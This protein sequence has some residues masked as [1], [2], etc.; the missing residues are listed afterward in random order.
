K[1]PQ[2]L[3]PLA[4][5]RPNEGDTGQIAPGSRQARDNAGSVRERGLTKDDWNR[6]GR[7]LCSKGRGSAE[8]ADDV[9]LEFSER[10]CEPR[11]PGRVTVS[12]AGFNSNVPPLDVTQRR[13]TLSQRLKFVRACRRRGWGEPADSVNLP[14]RRA[15]ERRKRETQNENDREPDPPHRHLGWDGWRESS[16]T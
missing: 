13:Q 2:E 6:S 9:Y 8:A 11:Q 15:G 12:P 5:F 7:L 10:T 16:R 4:V 14:L 1:L 3:Q